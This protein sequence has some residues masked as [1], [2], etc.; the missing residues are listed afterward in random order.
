MIAA[1]VELAAFAGKTGASI[2]ANMLYRRNNQGPNG[3]LDNPSDVNLG[4]QGAILG[5]LLE[6]GLK[7]G[8]FHTSTCQ[9]RNARS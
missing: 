3:S 1:F 7:D 8:S 5:G 6:D 4:E 9:D 2:Y